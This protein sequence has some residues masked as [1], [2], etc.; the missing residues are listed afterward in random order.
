M[1][2]A[3]AV[4]ELAMALAM[5]IARQIPLIDRRIRAGE[6]V[7]KAEGSNGIQLAG[8]TLGLIGGGNIGYQLGKMFFGAFD[9]PI[10]IYDPFLSPAMSDKWAELIPHSHL[11]VVSTLE[12]LLRTADVVS[13]HIPLNDH[14]CNLIGAKELG[15]MKPSAIL[16]NTARGGIVNE[17]ALVEALD[18][19]MLLGAGLDAF[20]IEPPTADVFPRLIA[21]PRVVST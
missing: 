5:S 3:G 14:T 15:Y 17:D 10:V 9:S 8:R 13:L 16:I 2:Q 19:G 4:A 21:H 1:L 20:S 11:T 6:T 7:T 12:E 18:Q